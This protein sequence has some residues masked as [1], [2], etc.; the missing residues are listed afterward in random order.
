VVLF[1]GTVEEEPRNYILSF[2][3]ICTNR[4]LSQC[5]FWET[6]IFF[7]HLLLQIFL[8]ILNSFSVVIDRTSTF[9]KSLVGKTSGAQVA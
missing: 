3:G 9:K 5:P 4:N 7:K 8:N 1:H 6:C 2:H